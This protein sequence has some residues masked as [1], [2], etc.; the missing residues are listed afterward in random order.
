MCWGGAPGLCM[1]TPHV[2][3][4]LAGRRLHTRTCVTLCWS[5][6]TCCAKSL[7]GE[8]PCGSAVHG[9]VD[10]MSAAL[11][12][13]PPTPPLPPSPPPCLDPRWICVCMTCGR[14]GGQGRINDITGKGLRTA[15]VLSTASCLKF[16]E[17]RVCIYVCVYCCVGL[18]VCVCFCDVCVVVETVFE[19][20]FTKALPSSAFSCLRT[21]LKNS[22][23]GRTTERAGRKTSRVASL[24]RDAT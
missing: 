11:L 18:C 1:D 7:Q 14:Q 5:V 10:E 17:V 23:C 9:K 24:R 21:R 3:G 13:P 6:D 22:V 2:R 8:A 12:P 4:C 19:T 16:V 20:K 15:V